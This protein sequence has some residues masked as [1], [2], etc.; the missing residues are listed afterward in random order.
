[1][2]RLH[3]VQNTSGLRL[4]KRRRGPVRQN[5]Q[6]GISSCRRPRRRPRFDEPATEARQQKKKMVDAALANTPRICLPRKG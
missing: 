4:I 6:Q 3:A 1:M 5:S 2:T